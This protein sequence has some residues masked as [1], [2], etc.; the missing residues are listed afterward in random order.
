MFH[1]G[2]IKIAL[3]VLDLQD[4]GV[5]RDEGP[6]AIFISVLLDDLTRRSFP[7]RIRGESFEGVHKAHSY[8]PM[9]PVWWGLN[10][11]GQN[12]NIG[13]LI[14]HPVD[15]GDPFGPSGDCFK[16]RARKS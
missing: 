7:P 1:E 5:S 2:Q 3:D 4:E 13:K 11:G 15:L 14:N 12:S 16:T 10:V 9:V 8:W 6:S